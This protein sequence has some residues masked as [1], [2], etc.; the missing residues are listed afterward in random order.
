MRLKSQPYALVNTIMYRPVASV[1]P[2]KFPLDDHG[3]KDR[4][5]RPRRCILTVCRGW[6][7]RLFPV[8]SFS[9]RRAYSSGAGF[10]SL[11]MVP[12]ERV[13]R[14]ERSATNA[15]LRGD[16]GQF[17]LG[18]QS[19]NLRKNRRPPAR[20]G[21]RSALRLLHDLRRKPPAVAENTGDFAKWLVRRDSKKVLAHD[22]GI[23]LLDGYIPG[24]KVQRSQV[25]WERVN[26]APIKARQQFL[27][28][29]ALIKVKLAVVRADEKCPT[30][31][32]RIKCGRVGVSNAEGIDD[33]S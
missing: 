2:Y 31:A 17:A 11:A 30:P 14:H 26:I 1:K 5:S 8:D 19:A 3:L 28:G 25:G 32:R 13:L 20:A 23:V 24:G 9:S 16:D 7:A 10:H 15:P 27:I 22:A 4:S 12:R 6:V 33:G 21:R 29:Q 18:F